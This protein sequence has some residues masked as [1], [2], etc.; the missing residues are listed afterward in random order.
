[1]ATKLS[2]GGGAKG[3]SGRAI[4]NI[5]FFAASLGRFG[6]IFLYATCLDL[7]TNKFIWGHFF[8]PTDRG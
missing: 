5:T 8:Y 3:L 7:L 1:M 4:K 6:K 2:V